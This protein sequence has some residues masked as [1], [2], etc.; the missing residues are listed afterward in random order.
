MIEYRARGAIKDVVIPRP[1][2][3]PKF[4]NDL[5]RSTCFESFIRADDTAYTEFNL[6]LSGDWAA[7]RFSGYRLAMRPA[8]LDSP[9]IAT[10]VGEDT[11]ILEA[12][13]PLEGDLGLSAVIEACD[14]SKSYWA[15]AHP[16]G[17]PDFHHRDCFT[18]TLPPRTRA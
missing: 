10:R 11:L 3:A 7:Y 8:A 15:L 5:W 4:A 17:V 13:L 9:D 14:G 1:A 6:S 2:S 18:L 12:L 16:P